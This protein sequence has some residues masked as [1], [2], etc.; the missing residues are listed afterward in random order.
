MTEGPYL[1]IA[2]FFLAKREV[3]RIQVGIFFV[4]T[5][6]DLHDAERLAY[7]TLPRVLRNSR[8]FELLYEL[9][10][11]GNRATTKSIVVML[12]RLALTATCE[13]CS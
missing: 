2:V 9:A 12:L 10:F 4:I 6:L 7:V 8:S 3:S 11:G 5:P 13:Y 1:L